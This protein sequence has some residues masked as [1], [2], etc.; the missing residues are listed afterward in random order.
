LGP[1]INI[2]TRTSGRP[3]AF[4][5]CVNS[6]KEQTYQNINHII[7]TDD[8]NNFGYIKENGYDNPYL[9]N[10]EELIKN[11]KSID[12]GTG[13]YSPH[14]LYFIEVKHLI[15]DGWVMYLDDDDLFNKE[16]ALDEIK[17]IINNVDEDT[18]IYWQM[19]YEN[20]MVLPQIINSKNPPRIGGI[21]SPCFTFHSK[22]IKYAQWDGWKCSDFRVINSLHN[23]IKKFKF[24]PKPLVLIPKAGFGNKNDIL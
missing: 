17:D 9:V 15:T 2:I 23:K 11:D 14:N 6:I 18:I 24:T 3:N 12:P 22:W 1:L 13:P 5:R 16:T 10:R 8:E 19:V 7:I 4:K 20:G 21:G